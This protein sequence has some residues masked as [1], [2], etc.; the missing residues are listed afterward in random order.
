[1]GSLFGLG[2]CLMTNLFGELDFLR[3][4]L[5]GL[6]FRPITNLAGYSLVGFHP[7]TSLSVVSFRPITNTLREPT[8]SPSKGRL[9]L[10]GT[11]AQDEKLLQPQQSVA[12]SDQKGRDLLVLAE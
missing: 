10:L 11:R 9:S 6:G 1:M 5:F 12:A 8:D 3:G 2:F 4:F 7:T